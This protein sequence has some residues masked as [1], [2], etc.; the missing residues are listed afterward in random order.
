MQEEI[1]ERIIFKTVDIPSLPPIAM[2]VMS[3]IQ[4]DYASLKSLEEIISRDQ[5]FATRLL[6]IANSPYYGRDRKIENI[7]QALL[8]IGFETLK[9]L[10]IATSLRDLHRRFGIFEQRLWEHSLGV[11][12]CSSLLA[13]VTHIATT[14]DALVCGLIHDV[15]KTVIN[16]TIPELYMQIYDRMTKEKRM[17]LEIEDEALGF[18][19]T[20]IGSLIS[21]KWKLPEKLEKVITYHHTYPYPDHED[22]AYADI[23]NVVRVADQ[24]CLNL[25]IGLKD[26]FTTNIDHESLGITEE[27]LNELIGLFKIKFDK[28]KDFLLS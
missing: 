18:N 3:L 5:G 26:P 9:S 16:N 7:P 21:K 23:C 11:A 4:D 8:I 19:H 22:Q 10:V 15:G 1:I 12:L 25:G 14:D 24:I 28:Q 20:V 13:M 27:E 6:R 17:L 2:K